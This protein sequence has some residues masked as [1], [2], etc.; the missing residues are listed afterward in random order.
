MGNTQ[1]LQEGP[2]DQEV[3]RMGKVLPL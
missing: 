3:L 1:D 2:G